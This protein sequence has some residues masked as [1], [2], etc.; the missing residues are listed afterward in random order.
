MENYTNCNI[1]CGF[2]ELDIT[3]FLGE[4]IPGYSSIRI[5]DGVKSKLSVKALAVGHSEVEAVII[6][7]DGIRTTTE[8]CDGI[9][10]RVLELV[11]VAQEKILVAATHN[12]TAATYFDNKIQK[13]DPFYTQFLIRRG[14][15]CAVM[16]IK[17]ME[18]GTIR[19]GC[20]KTENMAFIRNYRLKDGAIR[21]NPG[22][23]NPEI[24]A[25]IG[26]PDEDFPFMLFYNKDGKPLGALSSFSLHHDTV[27]GTEYCADFS[28]ALADELKQAYGRD[29]V[30]V[31]LAGFC[32]NVNHI[33]V[34]L[35]VEEWKHPVYLH[36]GKTL[37]RTMHEN[38]A[39]ACAMETTEVRSMKRTFEIEQRK[40]SPE[41]IEEAKALLKLDPATLGKPLGKYPELPAFKRAKA[42]VLIDYAKTQ[43]KPCT[44]VIQAIRIGDCIIYALCGEIYVEFQ[45]YLKE[46]SPA[47]F[48]MFSSLSNGSF[49]GYLPTQDMYE[50][51]TLYEAQLPSAKLKK[52][53]GE[54]LVEQL[55]EM[56][57]ALMK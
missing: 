39:Q 17:A 7:I 38:A 6:A 22:V 46:N 9:Y 2:Y 56:A 51:E 36:I 1:K 23:L 48:N 55:V 31:F 21:T 10:R 8:I 11:G 4:H 34:N 45:H 20:G 14:A 25:P 54:F 57:K 32:G 42:P 18:E 53:S 50:V 24:V 43:D 44:V 30:S 28:G 49:G 37:F 5:A 19:Y 26:Q 16:A 13:E 40:V 35:P 29:F 12:H 47:T 27:T 33:N 52:G 15:D 3:P 41:K